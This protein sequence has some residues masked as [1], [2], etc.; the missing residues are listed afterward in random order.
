[1]ASYQGL[2]SRDEYICL[3][4]LLQTGGSYPSVFRHQTAALSLISITDDWEAAQVEAEHS[5]WFAK[6]WEQKDIGH[7]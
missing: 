4:L 5:M 3:R 6:L 2:D 7:D 1:M